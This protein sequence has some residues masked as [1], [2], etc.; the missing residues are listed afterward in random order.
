MASRRILFARTVRL[1]TP[2]KAVE[3]VFAPFLN[4]VP[5][6]DGTKKIVG[7]STSQWKFSNCSPFV[8]TTYNKT[9]GLSKTYPLLPAQSIFVNLPSIS[10]D[11]LAN[12]EDPTD[13]LGLDAVA[14]KVFDDVVRTRGLSRD[15]TPDEWDKLRDEG[16][17]GNGKAYEKTSKL[18]FG[19]Q[20][21]VRMEMGLEQD[22][23]QKE[24]YIDRVAELFAGVCGFSS[25]PFKISVKPGKLKIAG[26]DI[27]SEPDVF[28]ILSKTRELVLIFEDKIS[29][30]DQGAMG[31][32]FG[33]MLMMHY[34]NRVVDKLPQPPTRVYCV[35]L[36]CTRGTLFSLDASE[37][38]LEDICIKRQV[39]HKK[40]S[41]LS[42]VRDPTKEEGLDLLVAS[43]RLT[44]TQDMANLRGL[45]L[46]QP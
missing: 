7:K 39:P 8:D 4:E 21:A 44:F 38:E 3:D 26:Y 32:V 24:R 5:R 40:L 41:L 19:L 2:L 33:E 27:A 36:H 1:R 25:K 9:L 45:L 42:T 15:K 23:R 16:Y 22:T 18:L 17:L 46:P 35:R 14:K 43:E 31:Q 13:M 11:E 37:G 29:M 10:A 28:V 34:L 20:D 12:S 30:K 6:A